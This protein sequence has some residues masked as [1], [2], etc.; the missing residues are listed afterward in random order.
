MLPLAGAQSQNATRAVY[1][2][3][4]V[5]IKIGIVESWN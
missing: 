3:T 5:D 4:P 1:T 2:V